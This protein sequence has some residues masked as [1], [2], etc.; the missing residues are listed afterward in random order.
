MKYFINFWLCSY[1]FS[2]LKH[3]FSVFRRTRVEGEEKCE[4]ILRWKEVAVACINWF[5]IPLT[6]FLPI[7]QTHD[8]DKAKSCPIKSFARLWFRR[9]VNA[10]LPIC[11]SREL[12]L[13]LCQDY[14][15]H[16]YPEKLLTLISIITCKMRHK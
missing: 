10:E 7:Y 4:Y 13:T 9:N 6:T 14:K 3:F 12:I 11:S 16:I 8:K 2:F 5:S 1:R 15:F